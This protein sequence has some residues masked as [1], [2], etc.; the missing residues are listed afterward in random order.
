MASRVGGP[1]GD[2]QGTVDHEVAVALHNAI[3]NGLAS[4]AGSPKNLV[5]EG[6]C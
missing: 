3:F 4:R 6:L 5:A 2:G 1:N